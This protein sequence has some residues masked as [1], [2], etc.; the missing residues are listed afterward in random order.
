MPKER[1]EQD[2]AQLM[3]FGARGVHL[4][5]LSY[6]MHS[7]IS[8]L[9]CQMLLVYKVIQIKTLSVMPLLRKVRFWEVGIK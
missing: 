7:K 5:V 1:R 9:V 6:Q 8:F 3:V 4:W 2:R